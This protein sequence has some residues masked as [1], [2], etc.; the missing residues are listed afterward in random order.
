MIARADKWECGFSVLQHINWASDLHCTTLKIGLFQAEREKGYSL[1][2]YSKHIRRNA[3]CLLLFFQGIIFIQ[4]SFISAIICQRITQRFFTE[5][6]IPYAN[7][8][9]LNPAVGRDDLF[10]AKLWSVIHIGLR[11]WVFLMIR[12]AILGWSQDELD[13]WF[14][15]FSCMNAS[16]VQIVIKNK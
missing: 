2:F 10:W 11:E 9:T 14:V 3:Q 7:P 16:R 5:R 15:C 13:L 8:C 12:Y 4:Q 1:Y 6:L